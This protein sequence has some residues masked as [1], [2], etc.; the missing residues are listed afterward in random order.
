[1]GEVTG[2]KRLRTRKDWEENVSWINT[3]IDLEG[4]PHDSAV[5]FLIGALDGHGHVS[6]RKPLGV[7]EALVYW[8]DGKLRLFLRYS[9]MGRVRIFLRL[10]CLCFPRPKNY[11]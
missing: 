1:M 5:G 3:Q 9:W 6:P 7:K 8:E 10:M 11:R 2:A 4:I